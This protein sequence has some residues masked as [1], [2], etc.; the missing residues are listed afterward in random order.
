MCHEDRQRD[1]AQVQRGRYSPNPPG[2]VT[3]NLAVSRPRLQVRALLS[4]WTTFFRA[5]RWL[6]RHFLSMFRNLWHPTFMGNK[7]AR[8]REK[9]KPKKQPP[10][11]LQ[12]SSVYIKPT[13][14]PKP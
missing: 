11:K 12:P 2:N 8:N 4:A 14:T 10:P 3:L 9:K 1:E 6:N 13:T 5:D 7:D